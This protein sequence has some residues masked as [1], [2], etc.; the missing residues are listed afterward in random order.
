MVCW[1]ADIAADMKKRYFPWIDY[2]KVIGILLMIAGHIWTVSAP[3]RQFIYTFHMP[4][5]FV[6]AGFLYTRMSLCDRLKK[7]WRSLLQPYL[8]I[9]FICLVIRL[10]AGIITEPDY[11]IP[12][13]LWK[14]LCAVFIG[15]S[16]KSAAFEP[17]CGPSWFILSI[18]VVH[19]LMCMKPEGRRSGTFF[20]ILASVMAI[21]IIVLLN[22][23]GVSPE[24]VWSQSIMA[25]P[26][27]CFGTALRKRYQ[28]HSTPVLVAF[29]V[30]CAAATAAVNHFNGPV[31]LNTINYGNN[32]LLYFAGSL[33]G[34]LMIFAMSR[35][36]GTLGNCRFVRTMASGTIVI[37]GFHRFG[38]VVADHLCAMTAIQSLLAALLIFLAFYPIILFCIKYFP[39]ITGYRNSNFYR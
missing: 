13:H 21:V 17:V 3:I 22:R 31:D 30:I 7:D 36:L 39:A 19:I 28:E 25:L 8:I 29:M 2:A 20:C 1:S 4:L 27:F 34:T 16:M 11:D 37:V 14:M 35:I 12:E 6:I 23:A 5:F 38:I 9:N 26:F 10:G 32:V 15:E 18:F 24:G 33:T